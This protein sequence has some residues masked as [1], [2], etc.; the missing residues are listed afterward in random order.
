MGSHI[1]TSSRIRFTIQVSMLI[2]EQNFPISRRELESG[3]C[4]DSKVCGRLSG[5]WRYMPLCTI[6]SILAVTWF[7]PRTTEVSDCAHLRLGTAL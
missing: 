4:V 6:Y 2:T 3:S 7:Q 1:E 5:S